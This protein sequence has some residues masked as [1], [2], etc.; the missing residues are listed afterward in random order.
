MGAT[1]SLAHLRSVFTALARSQSLAK[2]A[3]IRASAGWGPIDAAVAQQAVVVSGE[4]SAKRSAAPSLGKKCTRPLLA[5][6]HAS[7]EP[8]F[9][10]LADMMVGA[11]SITRPQNSGV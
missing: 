5:S 1:G 11:F 4:S 8:G 9:E 6:R 10:N 2:M 3:S 7:S